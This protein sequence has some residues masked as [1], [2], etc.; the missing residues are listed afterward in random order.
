MDDISNPPPN[1][2]RSWLTIWYAPGK[3]IRQIATAD[4]E[5]AAYFIT[6]L[7]VFLFT[8]KANGLVQ[9]VKL[10]W[11]KGLFS[12]LGA[13]LSFAFSLAVAIVLA[14]LVLYAL[15]AGLYWVNRKLGGKASYLA[16]LG[17]LG[18]SLTPGLLVGFALTMLNLLFHVDGLPFKVIVPI[19]SIMLIWQTVILVTGIRA[20]ENFSF[21][22]AIMSVFIGLGPLIIP[23]YAAIFYFAIHLLFPSAG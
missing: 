17:A 12:L 10:F 7:Y 19:F 11:P 4:P 6:A 8:G 2:Y 9:I 1:L 5:F 21:P 18:W 14:R 13:L 15:S 22:R 16:V 3:T 23:G 20:I